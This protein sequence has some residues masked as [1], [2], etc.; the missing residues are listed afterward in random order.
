MPIVYEILYV[1]HNLC[2]QQA[3]ITIKPL[4]GKLTLLSIL[5]C[6]V[7]LGKSAGGHLYGCYFD[8]CHLLKHFCK[9]LTLLPSHLII[10]PPPVATA[11]ARQQWAPQKMCRKKVMN[12][13]WGVQP[14]NSPHANL[15]AQYIEPPPNTHTHTKQGSTTNVLFSN[16]NHHPLPSLFL[17][18]LN[19]CFSSFLYWHYE[20]TGMGNKWAD[21]ARFYYRGTRVLAE[22]TVIA[23]SGA[24]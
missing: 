12:K 17:S 3:A 22:V 13:L 16:T 21:L 6:N 11:S 9:T 18:L 4:T 7:L 23:F 14:H 15:M 5:Q 8:T 19:C 10:S 20:E 2:I 24:S 1:Q